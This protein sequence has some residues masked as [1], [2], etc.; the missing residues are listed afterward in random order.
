MMMRNRRLRIIGFANDKMRFYNWMLKIV[1]E[2]LQIDQSGALWWSEGGVE[3]IAPP[4]GH[5]QFF[6]TLISSANHAVAKTI[7]RKNI[8]GN[9]VSR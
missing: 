5:F 4:D 7:I 2:F 6:F 3:G 1:V 8:I 9:I